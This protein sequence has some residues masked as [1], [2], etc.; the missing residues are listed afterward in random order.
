[1]WSSVDW[2]TVTHYLQDFRGQPL[3]QYSESWMLLYDSFWAYHH[4]TMLVRYWL[5]YTGCRFRY[6]IQYKS[7]LVMYMAH[8]GQT[9]SYI[10]DAVTPI[11]QDPTR[12]RRHHRLRDTENTDQV[13]R[14]SILCGRTIWNYLPQSLRR[15]DCT[16]TFKRRLKTHFLTSTSALLCFNFSLFYWLL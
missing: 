15:T 1:M 14:V 12:R 4:V 6:R 8:T 7:A 5:T 11:S 16:Q 2:A 13:W 3:P 10:K 9:T